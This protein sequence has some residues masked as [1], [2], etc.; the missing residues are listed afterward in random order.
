[1]TVKKEATHIRV[2]S[3]RET[4]SLVDGPGLRIVLFLQGCDVHCP[5]C[6]NPGT[7]DPKLGTDWSIPKLVQK[8][9]SLATNKKVTISGGEPLMQKDALIALVKAL[10]GFDIALYTSHQKEEVPPEVMSR[11]HFLKYGPYVESLR[12]TSM[13]FYGSTNQVFLEVNHHV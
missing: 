6:H 5:G 3:I 13:P 4:P 9:R 2:H 1:M 11:L 7:W 8:L 10:E 12:T